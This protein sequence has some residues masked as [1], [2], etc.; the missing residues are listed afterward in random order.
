MERW[1]PET[2]SEEERAQTDKGQDKCY[3]IPLLVMTELT[4]IIVRVLKKT[5]VSA[6]DYVM[7][8]KIK[9]MR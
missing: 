5:L 6:K 3:Q 1:N 8:H 2:D 7:D 4:V 9:F